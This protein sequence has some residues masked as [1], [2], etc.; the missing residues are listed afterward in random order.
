[1]KLQKK[2]IKLNLTEECQK[3]SVETFFFDTEKMNPRVVDPLK[4]TNLDGS[5]KGIGMGNAVK[6]RWT[7]H[8]ETLK[9]FTV[10]ALKKA[11]KCV[12]FLDEPESALSLKNQYLLVKEIKEAIE[13]KCQIFLSTHSLVL[14]QSFPQVLS[15]EHKK[16]MKS[17]DFISFNVP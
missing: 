16:W 10:N 2:F 7:S 4:Y 14:I 11:S 12:I 17:E 1:M 6:S 5:N 3:Q 15:I 13:R 8:G 9:E